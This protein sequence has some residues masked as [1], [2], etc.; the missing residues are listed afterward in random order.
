MGYIKPMWIASVARTSHNSYY[1]YIVDK[2]INM[3]GYLKFL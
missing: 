3:V 2:A 1:D